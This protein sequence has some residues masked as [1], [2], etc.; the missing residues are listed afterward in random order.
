MSLPPFSALEVVQSGAVPLDKVLVPL[1]VAVGLAVAVERF[2]EFL[3][4]IVDV[5]PTSA[6]AAVIGSEIK[7]AD[8]EI[9]KLKEFSS[10]AESD[11]DVP[12]E[13]PLETI[14]VQPATDPDDGT[15]MRTFS[16]Q[17]AAIIVGIVAARLSK[18]QLFTAFG[19]ELPN[20]AMDYVFTGL[21]IGGGSGPAHVLIRFI[22]QRKFSARVEETERAEKPA[23][24]EAVV[25]VA[26]EETP[27]ATGIGAAARVIA[28]A[29][30]SPAP[31]IDGTLDIPYGGGVDR[32]KLQSVH[33]RPANPQLIVYHHTAMRLNSTFEDVVNVIK[34]D[35]GW[36]TGYNCVIT[37][38][39]VVHPF[40]RWDRYGNHA[41]NFNARSLGITLNGNFETDPKVPYSNPD[42][43]YGAPRPTEQ[44]LDAAARVVALW[45]YVYPDIPLDFTGR[46]RGIVPHT[47]IATTKKTCPGNMFPMQRFEQLVR[48]YHKIWGASGDARD[49]IEAFKM[50]PYLYVDSRIPRTTW[51]QTAVAGQPATAPAVVAGVPTPTATVGGGN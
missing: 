9:E 3:K 5:M 27:A 23:T 42:G 22:T 1:T 37:S 24:V 33:L 39:G 45:L 15:T 38:D 12:D 50:R 16:I 6:D 30:A 21:F 25:A 44:Q 36:I 17:A 46:D 43:R 49:R 7:R 29:S 41:Q 31:N 48:H 18:L 32:D 34:K 8:A 2:V 40:C 35:R 19:V 4:N 26:A 28:R 10:A 14:L 47:R 13:H 20:V 51:P 11:A